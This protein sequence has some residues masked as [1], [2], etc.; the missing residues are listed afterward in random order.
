MIRGQELS[1]RMVGGGMA[2]VTVALGVDRQGIIV[3]PADMLDKPGYQ[4]MLDL[5]AT[6]HDGLKRVRE[7]GAL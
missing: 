7:G 2:E 6:H 4:D 1:R 3:V 5:Q